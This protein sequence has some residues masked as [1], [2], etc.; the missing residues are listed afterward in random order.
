MNR[1]SSLRK[2]LNRIFS[3]LLGFSAVLATLPAI[4]AAQGS[5]A[6]TEAFLKADD[7]KMSGKC[8]IRVNFT[9]YI[10]ANGA[11]TVK[12]TFV[13][14]DGATAPVYALD[15][16]AAGT[17]AVSTDW[18]LGDAAVLPYY[19][20]WQTIKIL[21]PNELESNRETG[22]FSISCGSASSPDYK[23]SESRSDEKK[24]SQ[25][26]DLFKQKLPPMRDGKIDRPRPD[27]PGC[28][29]L[30]GGC[31]TEPEA[32]RFRITINGF[33]CNR[34]TDDKFLDEDGA[35]DEVFLRTDA[36][37]YDRSTN[38]N[39]P[40]RQSPVIGDS[41]TRPER[42]RAGRA[43]SIGGGNGGFEEGNAFPSGATPWVR[44]APPPTDRPPLIA[45]EGQL[46]RDADALALI[47][48]FWESD[49][50]SRI[51]N[52]EWTSSVAN[53]F[54]GIGS[55]MHLAISRRSGSAPTSVMQSALNR[56][57]DPVRVPGAGD[58]DRDRPIGMENRGNHYGYAPQMLV[59]SYDA[60]DRIARA[61]A[62][63][64]PGIIPL[65]FKDNGEMR[66]DYTVFV[67]IE[68]VDQNPNNCAADSPAAFD[69]NATMTTSHPNA[70]GPF[71]QSLSLGINLTNCRGMISI[72]QFPP[73]SVTFPTPLGDNTT[74]LSMLSGGSGTFNAATGRIEIPVRLGLT[75]TIGLAGMSVIELTLS[76]E[77]PG[78][79]RHSMGRAT[80]TGSGTFRGGFL[81]GQ[82]GSFVVAGSFT[83]GL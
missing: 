69:G 7:A 4:V 36:S 43:T 33:R 5:F 9:G 79:S 2:L 3:Y 55:E 72:A 71:N 30:P 73:I 38:R 47:P 29:T 75:N 45:W 23:P 51:L 78:A 44:I 18:T 80:L 19:E 68:R 61:D 58:N 20:G 57:F 31:P 63:F 81:D 76:T 24:I 64:S 16:K 40:M 42:I 15:F 8:P 1:S 41:N 46:T 14:N 17:Q 67:Q 82:T 21:S 65:S 39:Q 49:V 77:N 11:G 26:A 13:R 56:F 70:R 6:V 66:G 28:E 48:S 37:L 62:G 10:T 27:A 83:P 54:A 52:T 50:N 74:T 59:L 35:K 25:T 22:K 60:A 12:Y 34:R 32:A 53:A